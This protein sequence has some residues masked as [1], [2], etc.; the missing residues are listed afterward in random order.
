MGLLLVLRPPQARPKSLRRATRA[1]RRAHRR[2]NAE[3]WAVAKDRGWLLD[4]PVETL[5]PLVNSVG[6]S[7]LQVLGQLDPWSDSVLDHGELPHLVADLDRLESAASDAAQGELV[8]AVR[9]LLEHWRVEPN[10]L[11]HCYGD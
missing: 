6:E 3:E 4:V 7:S 5:L 11:L 1:Q 2:A 9:V 10:L 8:T